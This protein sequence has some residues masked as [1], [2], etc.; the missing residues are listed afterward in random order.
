MD[1]P[2]FTIVIPTFNSAQTLKRSLDSVLG[3]GFTQLEILVIDGVSTDNTLDIIRT[4][5]LK[6]NRLQ[7]ISEQDSG[8]YDAMNK[9]IK[10]ASG[11]WIYFLGSDDRLYD[12]SVLEKIHLVIT[13]GNYLLVYGYIITEKYGRYGGPVSANDLLKKNISIL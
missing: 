10:R 8:I 12:D 2:F 7:Y 4:C 5:S 6:D 1:Q 9:G 13:G 3:Q 11:D